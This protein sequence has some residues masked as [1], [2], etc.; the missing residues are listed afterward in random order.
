MLH[1]V[2]I[3][4]SALL[5][6][7]PLAFVLVIAASFAPLSSAAEPLVTGASLL[8]P[9]TLR[10]DPELAAGILGLVVLAICL[11][12]PSGPSAARGWKR[13]PASAAIAKAAKEVL[14]AS[15]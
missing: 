13:T 14:A 7:S 15:G 1:L 8:L 6:E 5:L 2:V 12:V 3:L 11:L 9:A 4:V 10:P